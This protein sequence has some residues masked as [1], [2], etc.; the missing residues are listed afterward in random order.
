MGNGGSHTL[1]EWLALKIKYQFMCLCCKKTEPEITLS[2]D[3]IVPLS[4]GGTDNITNIQPLCR[5]CNS[6]KK[7]K[8]IIYFSEFLTEQRP[9]REMAKEEMM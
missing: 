8:T 4:K 5:S 1:E 7:D 2:E 3:H 9:A 6:R